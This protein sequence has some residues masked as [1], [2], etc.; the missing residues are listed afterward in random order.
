MT[1]PHAECEP[2]VNDPPPAEQMF[3]DV[4]RRTDE[5][6]ATLGHEMRNP[7]SALSTA[8]QVWRG[9]KHNPVQM[10]ELRNIMERQVHQLTRLSDNLLDVARIAQ[11]KLELRR[12]HVG[13]KQLIEDA[14]EEVRPLIDHCGHVLTVSLPAEPLVV[15]GDAS[16]LLQVFANLIQNAAKFTGRNGSL[17]V[18]VEPREG[19]AAVRVRDNGPGIEEYML[20]AIFDGSRQVNRTRTPGNDGLGIGLRLV[21]T[22]VELH[23]GA[24]AARSEGLGRGSEFTVLLPVIND[25]EQ[26]ATEQPAA[27]HNGNGH[28]RQGH[29]IV[30]VDDNRSLAELLARELRAM[31]QTVAVADNGATA[32]RTVLE[33]RPQVV[34]LDIVMRGIDGCE[35]ARQLRGHPELAGLVLIA[36]S[37]NGAEE[38]KRRATDAGFDK[39]FV[40]PTSM[41]VLADTLASIPFAN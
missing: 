20:S 15:Y 6:L 40:K 41:A 17:C 39:Y 27:G 14:C 35:V 26:P 32:I 29:R 1:T 30:V 10:E 12:E 7:L 4:N 18:T 13:L 24:V 5:F 11:G 37:G 31:G 25:A 33:E 2:A 16:R 3:L 8:L 9:A 21:K 23:G 19:M 34:F 36:L 28:R 22:I 38:S